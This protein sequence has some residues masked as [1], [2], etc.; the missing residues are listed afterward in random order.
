MLLQCT[1]QKCSQA[2]QALAIA[3]ILAPVLGK[4]IEY[5]AEILQRTNLRIRHIGDETDIQL[6][7]LHLES[8]GAMI[9]IAPEPTN[10][11]RSSQPEDENEEDDEDDNDPGRMLTD[12][13]LA[14]ALGSRRDIFSVDKSQYLSRVEMACLFVAMVAGGVMS[15]MQ[16]ADAITMG[17]DF[18]SDKTPG[19]TVVIGP[20]VDR[21]FVDKPAPAPQKSLPPMPTRRQLHSRNHAPALDRG[22]NHG[23]GG[24]HLSRIT[25]RG[26]IGLLADKITGRSLE[27]GDLFGKGG[28]AERIDAILSGGQGLAMGGSGGAGR[29]G[30]AGIGVGLGYG[31]GYGG[32]SSQADIDGLMNAA[33]PE[34]ALP[35]HREINPKWHGDMVADSIRP[36]TG[37]RNKASIMR[38]IQ[39][40]IA[41]LR[42]AYNRYLRESPALQGKVT[43]KFAIDEFGKVLF[44]EVTNSSTGNDQFDQTIAAKIK[45]WAFEKIDMPGDVTEVVYPFVFSM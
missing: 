1:I 31:S 18:V 32:G 29:R 11:P 40:N 35:K 5:L 9:E 12:A 25:K 30:E 28:Y 17:P 7:Q 19:P 21:P 34:L 13:E 23:G 14:A 16:I 15:R 4:P 39:Q 41:A 26:V 33:M 44:C 6:L 27:G 22:T 24:D 36:I 42:Y 43:I 3:A 45:H 8:L 37:G 20:T 10:V 2:G 38:V